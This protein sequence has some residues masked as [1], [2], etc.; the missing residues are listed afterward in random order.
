[1]SR[2]RFTILYAGRA[3][4]LPRPIADA[5]E[6]AGYSVS[7]RRRVPATRSSG[8]YEVELDRTA[9]PR[10]QRAAGGEAASVPSTAMSLQGL[11]ERVG[12]TQGEIARRV[13]MTQSQL[14]RVEARKDHLTSTLRKY[15]RALGGRIEVVAV[16]NGKRV[17]LQGV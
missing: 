9:R 12:R 11:R 5:F 1:M 6:N 2:A 7:V 16:V 14:S 15:V 13:S 3:P 17:V 8:L 4:Q 10:R